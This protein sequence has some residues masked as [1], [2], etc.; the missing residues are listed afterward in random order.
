M[1]RLKLAILPIFLFLCLVLGGS[2]RGI[3]ANAFL[4]LV[5]TVILAWALLSRD[6]PVLTSSAR[7]LLL[8][9]AALGLLFAVQLLPLPPSIWAAIPGRDFVARGFE[10]LRMPR[11][12]MPL[13]LSPY[14][15][16]ASALTL[17]PPL[18]LLVAM[19]RL[20]SWQAEHLFVALL[21]GAAVSILLGVLQVRSGDGWYFYEI[22][23]LGVAVGTFANANHFAT[24]LL[25]AMP[26]FCALAVGRWR[27]SERR[28]RPLVL[29]VSAAGLALLFIGA[30]MCRSAAFLLLGPPV[31]AASVLMSVR[32]KPKRIGQGLLAVALLIVLA[33]GALVFAGDRIPG[34]GTSASVETRKQYWA[35][36]LEASEGQALTGWGFGTFQQAYRR[37]E[38]ANAVDR[39][40][41]NHAHNDYVEIAVEGGIPALLLVAIFMLWWAA[42]AWSAWKSPGAMIE[43]KAASIASAAILLHSLFDFPL[44]TSA[45]SASLALCL[46]LLA[47]ACGATRLRAGDQPR[48]ATL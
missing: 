11:P 6:P 37:Y 25:V 47:G 10:L 23:N 14:D 17:L 45:I 36:S 33:A 41:I 32:L 13:S 21:A 29:V 35:T 48:H 9:V 19:L 40:Y 44:R 4:Q 12:W 42:Q 1:S 18:A 2:S 38:D 24:L 31:V 46:A 22:T 7:R 5:A 39:F 20:R 34:S 43:Q 15:T 3:A 16:I 30:L 28:S 27:E 8:I 26:V